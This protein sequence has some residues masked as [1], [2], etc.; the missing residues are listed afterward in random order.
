MITRP[1][2]QVVWGDM[3]VFLGWQDGAVFSRLPHLD[4]SG[5][6]GLFHGLPVLDGVSSISDIWHIG[7]LRVR[8]DGGQSLGPKLINPFGQVLAHSR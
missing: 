3:T 8:N 7:L 5:L 6:T 4:S 2:H 1:F